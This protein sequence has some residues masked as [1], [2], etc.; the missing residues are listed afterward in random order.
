M[1]T[2]LAPAGESAQA[3]G[4]LHNHTQ[5]RGGR[6]VRT[7]REE[8]LQGPEAKFLK[9]FASNTVSDD[10]FLV[11]VLTGPQYCRIPRSVPEELRA[12]YLSAIRRHL[13]TKYGLADRRGHG[14]G[15][16]TATYRNGLRGP[17]E[18][19]TKLGDILRART[20]SVS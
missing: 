4:S 1:A 6:T 18:V 20:T 7:V 12:E 19:N 17:G 16:L 2:S 15:A 9:G 13:E 10:T 5:R 11:G 3:H 8:D 14:I